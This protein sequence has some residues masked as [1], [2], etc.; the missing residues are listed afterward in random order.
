MVHDLE[1]PT[2]KP[3]DSLRDEAANLLSSRYG[4]VQTETRVEG[5]KADIFFF[6]TDFGKQ[7][8][9]YVEAKD[10]N[11]CLGRNE[12]VN[13]WSD[14]SGIIEKNKPAQLLLITRC[15][16]TSDAQSFVSIE[17]AAMRHQSIWELE[18]EI[19]GLTDYIRSL[20]AE[21]DE[22]GLKEYYIPGRASE[23]YYQNGD[24]KSSSESIDIFDTIKMWLKNED[25]T[26]IAILGG[27]GAG[28]TSLAK[29]LVSTQAESALRDPTARRPILIKLSTF[30]RHAELSGLLGGMFTN[31]YRVEGYSFP[32]FLDRNRKGRLFIILD[33]F[34]E[35]KHAMTWADFR[36]TLKELNK[37]VGGMSKVLLL[38]RPS[39]FTSES[40]HNHVLRGLR[41]LGSDWQRIEGWPTF[42]EYDLKDFSIEERQKFVYRFLRYRQKNGIIKASDEQVTERANEVNKLASKDLELFS[43]PV[44]AKILT[45]LTSSPELDLS[46]FSKGVSKWNLYETFFQLLAEREVEKDVRRPISEEHRLSFLRE[47]AFWL[48]SAKG[49]A[50]AFEAEDIPDFLFKSLENSDGCDPEGIKR[51]YL[52]GSFLEK[53]SGDIFYFSHRSF[54]EFLVAERMVKSPPAAAD[55]AT[56]S[57]LAKDGVSAFLS[58][59]PQ[60]DKIIEWK[61][62]LSEARGTLHFEYLNF[63][64]EKCGGLKNLYSELPKCLLK[65]ILIVFGSTLE[66]T[67][68]T[69]SQIYKRLRTQDNEEFFLLLH[70][71][72]IHIALS[73][74][75]IKKYLA[76]IAAAILDRVFETA[77]LD[78]S[79]Q[80]VHIQ[81]ISADS[82]MAAIQILPKIEDY[83]GDKIIYFDGTK[84]AQ[85]Q[86]DA[87]NKSGL[88]LNFQTPIKIPSFSS[89]SRIP[90]SD[91]HLLMKGRGRDIAK[92]YLQRHDD[93]KN[94][95]I[96]SYVPG[97]TTRAKKSRY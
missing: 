72:Q 66:F 64:S 14:Y 3:G 73:G 13:I 93:L 30:A 16:L 27:Y 7:V 86:S 18:N 62:T 15:G 52:T 70:V 51:E 49:G 25:T 97:K 23:A 21:F 90:V 12:V 4:P 29:R 36:A 11:T 84:L 42:R 91:I 87:I 76:A 74:G 9:V 75:N 80:R 5:K 17:Q 92:N 44:H 69:A 50:T 65:N 10:Y 1:N 83:H 60:N 43:K 46:R 26:P 67:A 82:R 40:Q 31:E 88:D 35:M 77:E 63:L 54:A 61:A 37:L 79:S 53:K 85:L 45:E 8:K 20:C 47:V 81:D 33:G 34:D 32:T 55:Q 22:G 57:A 24:R 2:P 48:W 28:K 71:L 38:G 6:R 56:Y 41:Q 58:D 39:A 95:I 68:D 19:L 96:K 59:C 89:L 94:V 78:T